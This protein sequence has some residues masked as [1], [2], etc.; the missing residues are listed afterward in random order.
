MK[1]LKSS[2]QKLSESIV[3]SQ[4][5]KTRL[6]AFE[7]D[8]YSRARPHEVDPEL[9]FVELLNTVMSGARIQE[10]RGEA[11]APLIWGV[12]LS[13]RPPPPSPP[14]S[15][16]FRPNVNPDT[17]PLSAASFVSREDHCCLIHP[18]DS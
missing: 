15:S 14:S 4:E 1:S 2:L 5:W 6:E 9:R 3:A 10:A 16:D 8:V 17:E 13:E 12:E 7:A 11:L 18:R